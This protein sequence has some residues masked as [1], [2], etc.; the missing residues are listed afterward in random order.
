ML[1]RPL[2]VDLPKDED[3]HESALIISEAMRVLRKSGSNLVAE[4][5]ATTDTFLEW[6]HLPPEDVIDRETRSQYFYHAHARSETGDGPHDDEHGHFH[7][8]RRIDGPEGEDLV[9]LIGISM[10]A[11]GVPFRLFTVNQW[12][13]GDTWLPA[14]EV[15]ALLDGFEIDDTRPS[16]ALNLWLT[17]MVRLFRL[18]ITRLIEA[19]DRQIDA[20]K[21]EHPDCD[22]FED[23]ELEV[24]SVY[25]F[26]L[27]ETVR[28]VME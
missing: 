28:R 13:T 6:E 16:W 8:F 4:V 11:H 21:A 27:A 12:V 22:A 1:T 23:R 20:W 17:H 19:R 14:D 7:L 25:S 10:N 5:M 26:D 9:H 24:T 18:E 2:D 3:M 15:I